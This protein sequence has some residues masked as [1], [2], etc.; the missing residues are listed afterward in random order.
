MSLYILDTDHVT[1][2]QHNHPQVIAKLQTMTAA[3]LATTVITVEEQM[4]GRLAQLG[5]PGV[6]LPLAYA[7]LRTTLD[8][9]CG[10]TIL[11]FEAVAQQQYQTL[12]SQRIRSGTLD[13]RIAAI[14]L[15]QN[16]TVVT[17]NQRDFERVPGLRV[18]DWSRP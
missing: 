1:L 4:R 2:H 15:A 14:A 11:S 13:L 6:N 9:F 5:Q 10:L 16:A 7:Q 17:R 12:R 3:E 18:E 8:Y